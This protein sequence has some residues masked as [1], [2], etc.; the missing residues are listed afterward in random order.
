MWLTPCLEPDSILDTVKYRQIKQNTCY[1]EGKCF[2]GGKQ[3]INNDRDLYKQRFY[4][5][6]RGMPSAMKKIN[7]EG[8]NM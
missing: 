8:N 5:Q 6:K 2:S 3:A 4:R 7:Q 1:H